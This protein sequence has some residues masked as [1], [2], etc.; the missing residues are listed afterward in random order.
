MTEGERIINGLPVFHCARY[1]CWLTRAACE[2]RR[3]RAGDNKRRIHWFVD[4]ETCEE[5]GKTP[6]PKPVC[7]RCKLPEQ[8]KLTRKGYCV[9]CASA[10]CH[11]RRKKKKEA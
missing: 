6:V 7:K 11:S 9:K 10:L 1:G 8:G 5:C 2:K 3:A 4:W